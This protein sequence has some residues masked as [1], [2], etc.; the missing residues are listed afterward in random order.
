MLLI[1]DGV[2]STCTIQ[3]YV[4]RI[5]C[6]N[7]SLILAPMASPKTIFKYLAVAEEFNCQ[8][9]LPLVAMLY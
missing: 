9:Q 6:N 8:V 3:T 7:V 4:K 5:I 1:I 2:R